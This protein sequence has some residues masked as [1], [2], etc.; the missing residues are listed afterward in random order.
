MSRISQTADF[1]AAY[2]FCISHLYI[3]KK[4]KIFQNFL[5]IC[6]CTLTLLICTCCLSYF[7]NTK[8]PF[9]NTN[10]TSLL[11]QDIGVVNYVFL[12]MASHTIFNEISCISFSISCKLDV[13]APSDTRICLILLYISSFNIFVAF[14]AA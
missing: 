9:R 7:F 3:A 13:H 1:I 2:E 12:Y 4:F 8:R 11:T 5:I 10:F 6:L 14:T